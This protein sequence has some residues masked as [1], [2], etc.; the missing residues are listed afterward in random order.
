MIDALVNT[1]SF[2]GLLISLAWQAAQFSSEA[3][4]QV[5]V[6]TDAQ[7]AAI[8]IAFLAGVSEMTGQSAILI[9]NRTPLYRFIASLAYT[10]L[11]YIATALIWGL[12]AICVSITTGT[13]MLSW[14]EI[15]S[16]M[17]IL[18]LAFA[19]R[20]LGVL[21]ITPHIGP[22]I[23]NILEAWAL[24]LAIFGMHV[25]LD[26]SIFVATI[27]GLV[28]WLVSVAMRTIL[29]R[30]LRRPLAAMRIAVTGSTLEKSPQQILD[31]L[32][33]RLSRERNA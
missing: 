8:L 14:F 29:G 15:T 18:C 19:P 28:G 20:L 24:V 32:M 3:F 16:V 2:L 30:V 17:A 7:S 9:Y 13:G 11:S 23:A 10:G 27:V 25:A 31:D 22:G 33:L 4:M 1:L 5:T 6:A 21:T 26:L 12:S